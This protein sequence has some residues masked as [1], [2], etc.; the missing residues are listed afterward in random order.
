MGA[1]DYGFDGNDTA[2]DW[3]GDV[4]SGLDIDTHLDAALRYVD[5]FDRCRAAVYLL[6]VLGHSAYVWPGDLE[7][8]DEHVKKAAARLEAMLDPE[9]EAHRELV[10]LWGD[11]TSPVFD[12]IRG[13]LAGLR[14]AHPHRL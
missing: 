8:L 14:A 7:R 10:A 12:A 9:Q 1:W 3:F 6:T 13:E 11:E 5:D 2:A 4:F